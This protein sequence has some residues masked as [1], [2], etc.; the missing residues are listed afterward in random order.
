M[1]T[2]TLLYREAGST[3]PFVLHL[4]PVKK[5][6]ASVRSDVNGSVS[7]KFSSMLVDI[8][9]ELYIKTF[10]QGHI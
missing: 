9:A 3:H 10:N 2:V 5:A 6:C 7:F 1:C 8:A 4:S